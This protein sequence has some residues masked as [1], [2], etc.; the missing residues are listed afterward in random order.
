LEEVEAKQKKAEKG[1]AASARRQ[2]KKELEQ[3]GKKLLSF[4]DSLRKGKTEQHA[5]EKLADFLLTEAENKFKKAVQTG[6]VTD[7]TVAQTLLETTQLKRAE[8][9]ETAK[10]TNEIQKCVDKCKSTLLENFAKKPKKD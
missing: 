2:A 7:I 9:T 3:E 8:E 5:K 1:A 4:E 10:A 6:D